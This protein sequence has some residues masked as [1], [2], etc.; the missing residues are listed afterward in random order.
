[1]EMRDAN[2]MTLKFG[3]VVSVEGRVDEESGRLLEYDVMDF[4]SADVEGSDE[5]LEY[6][7]LF[8][9][10]NSQSELIEPK[11]VYLTQYSLVHRQE[12]A[13]ILSDITLRGCLFEE[14]KQA[15]VLAIKNSAT[16]K[17]Q[18]SSEFGPFD[19]TFHFYR[20]GSQDVLFSI[21]LYKDEKFLEAKRE[22]IHSA[23]AK[24]GFIDILSEFFK[25]LI[26]ELAS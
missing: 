12:Q 20:A 16:L 6:V 11:K 10:H 5:H 17:L 9:R 19:R 7:V 14:T 22:A 1:M 8:S 18:F 4:E 13:G 21:N 23:W 3:D 2:G 15:A 25:G 26:K 24:E